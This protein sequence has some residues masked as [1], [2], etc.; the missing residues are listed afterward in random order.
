MGGRIEGAGGATITIIGVDALGGT[1]F[2]IPSDRIQAGTYLVGGAI[3]GGDV[4]VEGILPETQTPIVGKLREAG[5]NVE[6]GHDSVRVQADGRLKAVNIRTMPY[7]GFP[8]D[9]QQPACALLSVCEGTS[10]VEETI[11]EG[12]IG[13]IQELNR[14]GAQ[15]ALRDRTSII[16]GV[17]RLQGANVEAS[18]LRAGAALVLA[19]L[20]AEGETV[21]RNV[22]YIDR[23]YENIEA[24][25]TA[26][27]G[28]IKRL[29]V[30]DPSP[31]LV[32]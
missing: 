19:G 17:A 30:E 15:I 4:T 16:S 21:I 12:R 23:G 6:V 9:M 10:L 25:I 8:T 27:G 28:T 7:P 32:H 1:R 14:M 26:L 3:T 22:H 20:V 13:H 2:R 11:Y 31:T 24:T 29:T 5:A 18:D